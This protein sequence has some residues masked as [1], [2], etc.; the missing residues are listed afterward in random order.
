MCVCVCQVSS[1]YYHLESRFRRISSL[2]ILLSGCFHDLETLKITASILSGRIPGRL[3]R[4][5][6]KK[7]TRK[8]SV[9][10]AV[11]GNE[12]LANAARFDIVNIL[13]AE[14]EQGGTGTSHLSDDCPR[15]SAIGTS[16]PI[17]PV[18]PASPRVP[19]LPNVAKSM[20]LT[21]S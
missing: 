20:A 13:R 9:I 11:V 4:S 12:N 15:H 8:I 7:T 18:T 1:P 5:K 21:D 19:G 17:T 14:R 16:F 6:R 3:S 2:S 10:P